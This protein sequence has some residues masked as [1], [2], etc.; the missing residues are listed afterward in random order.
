MRTCSLGKIVVDYCETM[1]FAAATHH[2]GRRL[3]LRQD[4]EPVSTV[5]ASLVGKGIVYRACKYSSFIVAYMPL[6][7]CVVFES[8]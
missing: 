3:Q 8:D 1:N 7:A 4:C 6:I 5:F 2:G